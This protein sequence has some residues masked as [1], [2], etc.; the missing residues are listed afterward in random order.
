VNTTENLLWGHIKEFRRKFYVN[1]MIR[2]SI[3]LLLIAS[4]MFFLSVTGEGIAWAFQV[5]SVP[6]SFLPWGLPCWV[7]AVTQWCGL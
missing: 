3:G 6:V 2:G 7:S 1:R 5:V 4:S